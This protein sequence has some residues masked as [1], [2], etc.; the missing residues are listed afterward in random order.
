M[1]D[2]AQKNRERPDS[3]GRLESESIRV[4]G[5]VQGVGFRPFVFRL[6]HR[7]GIAGRVANTVHGVKIEAEA[8]PGALAEFVRALVQD[9]PPIA[10]VQSVRRKRTGLKGYSGFQIV[11]STSQAGR[12]TCISPDV[13]VCEDCLAEMRDP[14]N[15]RWRYPFINCTNCGPRF[16]IILDVPYDRANTTMNRFVMCELCGAEYHDP[17]DRRF[18][19]QPN[20]CPVCG[21]RCRL[22]DRQGNDMPLGEGLDP[23]QAA[24]RLLL[25]GA[26]LAVKGLGGF[27]LAVDASH[28][29]AAETLRARKRRQDKPF[30]VMFAGI[31]SVGRHCRLTARAAGMLAGPRRPIV[32][33]PKKY[34]GKLDQAV[35]P[36]SSDFGAML[37]YTPLH[38]LLLEAVEG[39]PLVMTSGNL[40]DEP[41]E[42]DNDRALENLAGVADYFL[43]HDRP[44]YL[45]ADD[46]VVQTAPGGKTFPARRSR[47][48]A[49]EPVRLGR[50]LP[51]VLAVG[52]QLKNTVCITRGRDAFISQH[53]G[54][55][56]SLETYRYFLLTVNQ[57]CRLFEVK[58][59][60]V[61]YDLH[62]GYLN[63]RWALVESGLRPEPV[64]HHHAHVVSCMADNRITG[65]VVGIAMDGTGYGPDGT[66]W[67]GEFLV[68]DET[69][70]RRA[71]HLPEV[72]L[73]GGEAA[74]HQ[75]WRT[76]RSLFAAALGRDA[77]DRLGLPLWEQAGRRRV[78]TVDRMLELGTNCPVSTGCGRYF[79][80]VAALLGVRG[81]SLYEGQAAVELESTAARAT[82]KK[83]RSYGFDLTERDGVLV[84]CLDTMLNEIARDAA[85]GVDPACIARGFHESLAQ[86]LAEST[87]R[88]ASG[89][90]IGRVVLSGGVFNN[91]ILITSLRRRLAGR[92]L[93]V[94]TH[95]RVPPGD[96][97]I[98]LGQAV[99]AARRLE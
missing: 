72:R 64:Q 77:L 87:G 50:R 28:P 95:R 59:E 34:G 52:A 21:P 36:F 65:R 98:S 96:G 49:P 44:I 24:G 38:H 16:T 4:T 60:A 33:L 45:R 31:E 5:I 92:G 10:S 74:I 48:Y 47:G 63:T 68:A 75:T 55:L 89:A 62:P 54:D 8:E 79:D 69:G 73:P 53:V 78:A 37:P 99:I 12:T 46:S 41:I 57:L 42:I 43:L 13:A 67:G 51:P 82:V 2:S 88:I 19:A 27:H 11:P 30:A 23:L 15:R 58:P 7:L 61:A 35:A 32:L 29:A 25:D 56:D 39:R 93:K 91:R 66:L 94:Y 97:G 26:V 22:V 18:H 1:H 40:S 83:A 17:Y 70:Y 80:A 85:A 20:A 76:A 86:A 9:A 90:G 14:S 71:G 84:P 3:E 6:A 81:E